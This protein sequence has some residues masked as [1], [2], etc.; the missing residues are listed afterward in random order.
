MSKNVISLAG[1]R[2]RKKPK[3]L[4][5]CPTFPGF[6]KLSSFSI[7]LME[8]L[9]QGLSPTVP[10]KLAYFMGA[11]EETPATIDERIQRTWKAFRELMLIFLEQVRVITGA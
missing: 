8:I 3:D 2:R 11:F 6:N 1:A 4:L 10:E 5:L 7:G 9:S